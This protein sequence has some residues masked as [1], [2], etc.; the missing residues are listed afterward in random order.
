MKLGLSWS[1]V[2]HSYI[3]LKRYFYDALGIGVNDEVSFTFIFFY[4]DSYT[5][6]TAIA[7]G[8][9]RISGITGA[10]ALTAIQKAADLGNNIKRIAQIKDQR[11]LLSHETEILEIR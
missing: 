9:R 7:K 1:Q 2:G 10:A 4:H 3:F 5:E 6:E 8:I 11:E